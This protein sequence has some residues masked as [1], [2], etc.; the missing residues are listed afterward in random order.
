M[1]NG[2]LAM[3][4]TFNDTGKHEQ[5]HPMWFAHVGYKFAKD[6]K[7][8]PVDPAAEAAFARYAAA[9]REALAKRSHDIA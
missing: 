6:G 5:R 3:K 2:K 7:L 9:A 4:D 1:T 8:E